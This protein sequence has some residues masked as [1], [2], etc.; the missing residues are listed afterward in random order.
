MY[1]YGGMFHPWFGFWGLGWPIMAAIAIIP[2]WRMCTR[3]GLSPWLSLLLI[4]PIANV[5]FV[6][7]LAFTDWP[8]LRGGAGP[9]AGAMGGPG[10]PPPG[11][12]SGPAPPDR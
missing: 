6:Y 4:V 2:F 9:G 1:M 7:Y 5:I 11:P 10:N 8:A 12:A 3:V